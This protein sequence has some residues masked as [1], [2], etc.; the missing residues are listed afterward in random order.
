MNK[1]LLALLSLPLLASAQVPAPSG[2]WEF[3]NAANIGQ[4]TVGSN[5]SVVGSVPTH[6]TTL[7]DGSKTLNGAITTVGGTPNRLLMTNSTGGNGGGTFTNEYTFLFDIF[8]PSGSRSSWRALFQ[9]NTSNSNDAEYF[10]R[11]SD[12]KIGIS[13]PLGYSANAI[14]DSAWIRLVLVFDVNASGTASTVRAY[15]NGS[16]FHTHN[17]TGGRDGAYGLEGSVLMF[18]DNSAENAAL[19]VGAMAFWGRTLDATQVAT[20]G[21]AGAAIINEAPVITQGTAY[22]LPSARLNGPTVTGTLNVTDTENDAITW[23]VSTPA[24]NG[25][26]AIN[27]SSNSQAGISYT[28]AANFTGTDSFVVRAADASGSDSITVNVTV[29]GGAVV[30]AEGA[31]ANFTAVM[32][33]GSQAITFNAAD[34]NGN[35]LTWSISSAAANGT[36]QVTGNNNTTGAIGYTPAANYFGTDTFTVRASN[37]VASDDIVV[38]VQVVY[39]SG[40]TKTFYQQNFNAAT[41]LPE[42][43][44]SAER[45]MS[46]GDNTP[47][48]NTP[49]G[50]GLGLTSG[51]NVYLNPANDRVPEFTGFNPMRSDFWS[52]V[53]DQGR[54]TAFARGSNV[55]AVADSDEY[56]DGSGTG[57]GGTEAE[58]NVFL[59]TPTFIVP[60]GAN[61]SEMTLSFLSSFRVEEDETSRVRVYLNGSSTPAA[62]LSVGD[63]GANPAVLLSYSWAQLG[64]PAAGST[65]QLEFGHEDAD[66]NWWWAIDDISVGIPNQG[67]VI[68]EGETAPLVGSINATTQAVFNVTD[69]DNDPITWSVSASPAHGTAQIVASSN[70][71]VTVSYTPALNYAGADTFTVRASD[72]AASDSIVVSVAVQNS[73]PVISEGETYNLSAVKDGGARTVTFHASDANNNPLTW[74]VSAAASNGSASVTGNNTEAVVS[75]TPASGYSGPDSFTVNVTDGAISD[76]IAVTVTV[77]DP[78]SNPRL[79][80]VSPHGTATPAPGVYQHARGTALTNSVTDETGAGTRHLC[81]GWTMTG[82]GPTSGTAKTMNMTLTRDSVLTWTF[83]TEHYVETAAATGG[84]INVSSGW[85]EAGRPLQITATPAAGKY[86]TGWT[87]DISGCQTGGKS[88]VIPMDRARSTITANFANNDNFTFVALPDTQ[89]YTSISSPT[90]LYTRQT[91][92]INDNRVNLNI[93]FVTHLGDIVNSPSSA[94][95]WTRATDAMNLMNNVTPYGTAPGNHD[96]G[97]N[98]TNYLIRFGPNPTHS[99]SIG[100]WIDPDNSQTYDWYRGASPRGYS[101]YQIVT[102]N[103]RDFMFLHMDMDAPDQ[104]LAWAAGVLNAHPKA[105]TMV[106]THNYLAETGGSGTYGSGT[107]QRGYTAQANIGTWGDRPDTNRP[108]DVFNAIVK[109]FRQVY[110]VICGHNFATYNLAKTNDAGKT[111][112]EVVADWQSLPNGGNAFLRIMEFRPS[113]NQIYNTSYSPYLGR[114]VDPNNNADHQGMLDLHDR[115]GS[116]FSLAMDFDTRFNTTLTVV[117][118]RGGVTPAVGS[119]QI[120]DGTPV[121]I[122]AQEQVVGQTRYRPSGWTLTG[123]QSSSGTGSSAVITHNGNASLTWSYTTEHYLTTGSVGSGIVSTNSGWHAAG[124]TVNI[125]AQPDAGASFV[126]WSGDLNGCTVTGTTIS[127]PMDRPRGPITAEFSSSLPAHEVTVVSPFPSVSPAPAVYSYE[128]GQTV[129]FTASDIVENDTRHLCTGYSVTG[130]VTQTGVGKSVDLPITGDLTVTWIWKTEYLLTTSATGPGTVSTGGGQW[131]EKDAAISVIA[132]ANTGGTFSAWSGDTGAGT[133]TLNQFAI[134]AMTRPVGPIIATFTTAM[135]SLNVVSSQPTTEPAPGTRSYPYGSTVEFI[136]IS[137]EAGGSR[138]RPSGWAL[139]G[140]TTGTG[141]NGKGSFVIT[142]DTTL[143]WSWSPEVLLSITSGAE[144]LVLPMNVAGWHP[145]GETVALTAVV[146]D[147]TD[148]WFQFRKWTGDVPVGSTNA[149]LNLVMDQPRSVTPDFAPRQ[150]TTGTPLWWLDRYAA[151]TGANFEAASST[152]GDGD[153]QIA[154]EEFVA[155][156][157]DLDPKQLF[158]VTTTTTNE[159]LSTVS[160]SVPVRERRLYQLMQSSSPDGTFTAAGAPFVPTPPAQ[161]LSIPLPANAGFLSVKAVFPVPGDRDEDPLDASV[162]PI[163]GSVLRP[164]VRIPA[165]SFTQGEDGGPVTT[166]PEHSTYIEAFSMDKFEVTRA[167]WEAV[168]T[169]GQAHGY[170]VPVT[171][172]FNQAPYDVPSDHPAVAVSWYDAVKWCNARSEME[173]RRPVYF[174]DTS[175]ASVYRTGSI[176]LTSAHVNWAGDG[177]RLPTEAEWE[178]ASRGG[179]DQKLFPWGDDAGERRANHWDYQI[180]KTRAPN[181]PYPYTERVGYFDGTQPGGAP[182]M[183]NAYGLYDMA[184]NAWEWVWDRMGLYAADKQ[185]NPHGPDTGTERLQRGGAWWNYVDQATNHQRLPFPPNGSDDYGMIGFR[186]VRGLHPNE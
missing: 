146:P 44:T 132:T 15:V 133:A 40:S 153:G 165:G 37:G 31:T 159:D 72:G 130:A 126:Q 104:D 131:V 29:E 2:L 169:W 66:N 54:S 1:S 22:S 68:A 9:S 142:G 147:P 35:P 17:F 183:A 91:R 74:S 46:A 152:D 134:A 100:R 173:G 13:S 175:G 149:Q 171:L 62:V 61:V 135:V 111:V 180:F 167:D 58:F 151:V 157:S 56:T 81:T 57:G 64:S 30:I 162:A 65:M 127:V 168:A 98:D 141:S 93:K 38:S 7:S 178:R 8:S 114:Y 55:I 145:L 115:N 41:L 166:R 176:D 122:T 88:I 120:E 76:S 34:S 53:D 52:N 177:Y 82:D 25:T 150:T 36:A 32:N 105:L 112:H 4:A 20:L 144:G 181:G 96:I 75:Y 92:W 158:E 90:D 3:N 164:M 18:A 60:A 185:Y 174:A 143:T 107:G 10:I 45:R 101:S 113:Q 118:P 102:V 16:L 83:R 94:S 79:T 67:P 128:E 156:N 110:M 47:V 140:A 148:D 33:G 139:S 95:Q 179:L 14:N 19:N 137:N 99:S 27:S 154:A 121:A 186:C 12:D 78:T 85:F 23:S 73:A 124:T 136:A 97:A 106:T 24:A 155:G 172:K 5:L 71:Q 84:T 87:G 77:T 123:G 6:A 26:A 86:F 48:W 160:L 69:A 49:E 184:G 70:T 161:T 42:Q 119:H 51:A 63:N 129:T 170:D 50:S 43:T 21:A 108:V 59:R 103:G 11:N 116:E 125:Q 39:S 89:N 28:P 80:I 163:S 182:D 138:E 117:S 109:P